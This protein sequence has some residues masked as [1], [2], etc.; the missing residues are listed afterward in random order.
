VEGRGKDCGEVC[1]SLIETG[2]KLTIFCECHV[3][4]FCG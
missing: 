3:M 1:A 2:F 4:A